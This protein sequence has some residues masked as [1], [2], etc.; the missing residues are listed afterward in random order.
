LLAIEHSILSFFALRY[1]VT[2]LG[3]YSV[4]SVAG[5]KKPGARGRAVLLF[6][7]EY[8]FAAA[9]VFVQFC[10]A[11]VEAEYV[12]DFEVIARISAFAVRA[13]SKVELCL[14]EREKVTHS[15]YLVGRQA[16]GAHD[17]FSCG[18]LC[19]FEACF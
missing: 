2:N 7:V 15:H 13:F 17:R 11:G 16:I 4:T 5:I 10:F 3:V 18:K 6:A 12:A 19:F 14:L 9:D 1:C 8:L